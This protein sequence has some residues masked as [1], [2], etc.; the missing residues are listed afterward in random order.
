MTGSESVYM[1]AIG[2]TTDGQRSTIE[3]VAAFSESRENLDEVLEGMDLA[4]SVFGRETV[5]IEGGAPFH[6]AFGSEWRWISKMY[7]RGGVMARK[8]RFGSF[9]PAL[10][11]ALSEW[12]KSR[13]ID[14]RVVDRI[15]LGE[16]KFPRSAAEA[17]ERGLV[18]I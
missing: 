3:H 14:V 10:R 8:Y 4:N 15:A 9:P 11:D 13:R 16:F 1:T 7:Q 2:R 6:A 12:L 18:R 5:D 17:I